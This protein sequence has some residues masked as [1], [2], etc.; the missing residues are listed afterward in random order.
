MKQRRILDMLLRCNKG[1]K[2]SDG[3]TEGSLN[4]DTNDV[5]CKL[6]G[7]VLSDVSQFTKI[8]M[9][10]IGDIKRNNN[11][12]AFIFNC[13]TCSKPVEAEINVGKVTGKGCSSGE[14]KINI[15]SF[16]IKAIEESQ[17][18]DFEGNNINVDRAG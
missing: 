2:K 16:M 12:K 9:K 4:I 17:K 5:E 1:C 18:R 3:N 7:E 8:S 14:C 13:N 11:K 6:C 10:N 15:T